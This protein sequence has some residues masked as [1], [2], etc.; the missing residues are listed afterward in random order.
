MSTFISLPFS[1]LKPFLHSILSVLTLSFVFL[2]SFPSFSVPLHFLP[3]FYT[4]SISYFSYLFPSTLFVT[5][6]LLRLLTYQLLYLFC[7]YFS[8]TLSFF[9]LLQNRYPHS[10]LS[11]PLYSSHLINV[12]TSSAI[13]LPPPTFIRACDLFL[14]SLT[15]PSIL[16][17]SLSFSYMLLTFPT[18]FFL[19]FFDVF[20]LFPSLAVTQ[21]V[22][23][24]YFSFYFL[25]S[26]F[27]LFPL[28]PFFQ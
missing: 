3:S 25:L 2:C 17:L 19:H 10:I 18:F 23:S 24:F 9:L 1:S 15:L 20:F 6:P 12:T 11:P 28:L 13:D 7:M 16:S 22:L 21:V 14:V 5:S 8:L 26:S 27:L 4:S